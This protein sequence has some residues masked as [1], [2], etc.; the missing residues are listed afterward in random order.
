MTENEQAGKQAK[1]A[2]GRQENRGI[3]LAVPNE[4]SRID[5]VVAVMSGKGGV[6]KSSVTALAAV[7]LRR[8]GLKVGILDGDI[9]GPSIP[10]LFGLNKDSL[11]LKFGVLPATTQT[12]IRLMSINLVLEQ[13]TDPVIWRGP[14]VGGAIKQFFEEI[15]WDH[16]DV[17][18]IDLPPGTGDA[19]LST[20][21]SLPVDGVVIVSSPQDVAVLVVKKAI[22]MVRLLEKPIIGLVENMAGIICPHCQQRIDVLG[23]S[24][25]EA[26]AAETGVPWLG[27]L[28]LDPALAGTAG[29]I[30]DYHS[31]AGDVVGRLADVIMAAGE[32]G[33]TS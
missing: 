9:T 30:E 23:P 26:L 27:S 22:K 3:E 11:S 19:P 17:L 15:N 10:R 33:P 14:L 6:G 29:S 7:E 12:G 31:P 24:Q 1:P 13:D 18:L 25:G 32:G 4:F 5:R 28:P 21:Q 2:G 20:L 16:L 8:R